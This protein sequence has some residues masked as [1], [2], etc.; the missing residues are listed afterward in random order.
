MDNTTAVISYTSPTTIQLRM[1]LGTVVDSALTTTVPPG[2]TPNSDGYVYASDGSP[3]GRVRANGTEWMEVDTYL[4]SDVDDLFDTTTDANGLRSAPVDD[5][6]QWTVRVNGSVVPIADFSRKSNILD[7]AETGFYDFT[8]RTVQNVFFELS[9]PLSVNDTV[10]I[11]Y[12]DT[13]FD[14]VTGSYQ[15]DQTISEAIHVN[16]TGYD[17]D[18]AIKTAFLSSWNGFQVDPDPANTSG[19]IEK[20]QSYATGLD[21]DVINEATG[22]VVLSGQ[23]ELAQGIGDGSNWWLNYQRAD[24]FSMDL[25]GLT[26]EGTY[27][28]VVDGVGRSESFD[29]SGTHWND[30]FDTS[31][32]GFYHQR[33]GIALEAPYTDW[34]RPRSL[35]PA[36][37][38][39]VYETTV[40]ITDTS[41]A[42]DP[43][44][45]KP[46]DLF[47]GNTTGT[48]LSD[49]WGG[50]HDAG[51]WD[52]R[53]QHLDAAR[54][55]VEL[56][57]L[58]TTW[59]LGIDAPIPEA[60]N[61]IPDLID[62]AIWG[63]EVFKRLQHSDGAVPG[64]VESTSYGS[65]ADT[66]FNDTRP[67][68][69]YGP[70]VWS[71]WKYAAAAAQIARALDPYDTTLAA[72]WLQS[73]IDAMTWA[74]ANIPP[75]SE[76][77]NGRYPEARNL[78]AAELYKTTGTESYNTLYQATTVYG[79][80]QPIEW[81]EQQWEAAFTYATTSHSGV[82]TTLQAAGIQALTD[83]ANQMMDE[84]YGSRPGFGYMADPYAPYAW[85][86]AQ[87]PSFS[88]DFLLRVHALTGNQTYLDRVVPDVDYALGA[89]PLNM[90]YMTG[91]DGVRSPEV[92]LNAD[93]D[94]LG[95]SPPPGI[96]IYGDVDIHAFGWAEYY[97]KMYDDA[98][99]N[100]YDAPV[101]E[102][103]Q[104]YSIFVPSTEYTVMQGIESMTF[105]TGYLAAEVG[106]AASSSG[107]LYNGTTGDDNVD[108]GAG[109]DTAFGF[110]GNDTIDGGPDNDS[111]SGGFGADVLLGNTGN[112][113]I[114]GDAGSDYIDGGNG[115]DSLL[116][117]N[118]SDTIDGGGGNDFISG[119]GFIDILSGGD[120]NDTI[121]GGA[122]SDVL[123]GDAGA[124]SLYGQAASDILDGGFGADY[125]NGGAANDELR[126]GTG[127]DT[128]LG[129]TGDDRLYGNGGADTYQFRAN[130]GNFDRLYDFQD[131]IDMIEFNIASVN[132]ISD[133]SL[134]NFFN[135]VDI[136]YGSGLVRVFGLNASDFSNADFTFL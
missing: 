46:F 121:Y 47:P 58:Q 76:Y 73:A 38:V 115:N 9:S 24:L 5:T 48:I 72:E 81:F 23:T 75:A 2:L 7:T 17:P 36:D 30:L 65:F 114:D 119:E 10:E 64:G 53:P 102:S 78:A 83:R 13:D 20:P 49:A 91:I 125:L 100:F 33:S 43:S 6:S 126:G 132:D 31:F 1:E 8:F 55:L 103:Y 84:N 89:N 90:V 130:H 98:W 80:G 50:W 74:E 28:V 61:G 122:N 109:D 86:T 105:V 124:D 101:S 71:S 54:K 27:H 79:T 51:D 59:S 118:G 67:F 16:L 97:S 52:R 25:S 40:K 11:S 113:T 108:L 99:P 35:H 12:N 107:S 57:E 129:S 19:G 45:P 117:S 22:N 3:L 68:Y 56:H 18:D 70:D 29:V 62:E 135:G 60:G 111:I 127:N 26:Q 42:W 131:G 95:K 94:G 66:S 15:P 133:L 112:D 93:A 96:T 87:M 123:N 69:A 4:A 39:Q 128:L 44:L 88:A 136:D 77:D 110:G 82:D 63:A 37:G 14:A 85:E 116:G 21:Y 32:S 34:D 92:I 134:T 120:A 41:E 106:A 104:G